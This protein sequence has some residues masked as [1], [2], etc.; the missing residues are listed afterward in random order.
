MDEAKIR[1]AAALLAEGL[2][3][4]VPAVVAGPWYI[5]TEAEKEAFAKANAVSLTD[6]DGYPGQN[7]DGTFPKNTAQTKI[8]AVA[9]ATDAASLLA[10]AK[11]GYRGDGTRTNWTKA[12][13]VA[14]RAKCYQLDHL[15]PDTPASADVVIAGA[16]NLAPQTAQYLVMLAAIVGDSPFMTPHLMTGSLDGTSDVVAANAYLTTSGGAAG[17]GIG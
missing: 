14:A 6:L 1:Q 2:G 8:A 4:T 5:P 17:P 10:Y 16:G 11:H 9:D 7:A 13:L 3:D 15:S 12:G